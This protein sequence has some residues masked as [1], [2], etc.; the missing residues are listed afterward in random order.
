MIGQLR[1]RIRTG[2]QSS[3]HRAATTGL[4][5][6]ALSVL[7]VGGSSC[8][9]AGKTGAYARTAVT[10][11]TVVAAAQFAIAAQAKALQ[12]D[13][14]AARLELV[15]IQRAEQQVVAGMNYR[16]QLKVRHDG[17]VKE[18]EAVVWWQAW[19]QEEPYRLTS[20]I[21]R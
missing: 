16:L 3:A 6:V 7:G 15:A 17:A 20:W 21:W 2:S 5:L 12:K 11:E 13:A 19:N 10:S 18:A 8:V 9:Q 14:P 1:G 4:L